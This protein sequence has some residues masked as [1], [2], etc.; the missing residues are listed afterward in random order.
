MIF[1]SLLIRKT[2]EDG[3]GIMNILR[4]GTTGDYRPLTFYNKDNRGFE[5]E[6]ISLALLL[7][8]FLGMRAEFVLTDWPSL[9]KDLKD[10]SFDIAIGGISMT[11]RR[12]NEMLMSVPYRKNGKTILCRAEDAERYKKLFE[13]AE[14]PCSR[15]MENPGG[16]NERFV[17]ERMPGCELIIH[18]RNEEIPGLIAA[19]AADLMITDAV[20]AAWAV[21]KEPRLAAPLMEK[22]FTEEPM[23]VLAA[24]GKEALMEKINAFLLYKYMPEK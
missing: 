16:T 17:R 10:G 4:I 20:E 14:I 23:A 11:E 18:E 3:C 21:K 8:A 2:D 13:S 15:I 6:D 24:K 12:R 22:L 7:A 5:G 1:Y 19:G 9:E